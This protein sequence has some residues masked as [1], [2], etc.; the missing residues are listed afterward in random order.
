[1]RVSQNASCCQLFRI[2]RKILRGAVN[3]LTVDLPYL[4]F[5]DLD[6]FAFEPGNILEASV[7]TGEADICYLIKLRKS[8]HYHFANLGGFNFL[9]TTSVNLLLDIGDKP[10]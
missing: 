6:Q 5:S 8:F 4:S 10:F 2:F 1:M 7:N 9:V 3:G